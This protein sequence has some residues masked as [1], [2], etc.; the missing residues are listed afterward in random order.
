MSLLTKR[1][2]FVNSQP[3]YWGRSVWDG[4]K[5]VTSGAYNGPPTEW[6]E[7]R[8]FSSVNTPGFKRLKKRAL[9]NNPFHAFCVKMTDSF[10]SVKQVGP[11]GTIYMGTGRAEMSTSISALRQNLYGPSYPNILNET[12]TRALK[13][14][15]NMKFNAAQAFAERRQTANLL[16]STANRVVSLAVLLREGKFEAA[17]RMLRGRVKNFTPEYR[18]TRNTIRRPT[19]KD[20]ESSWLEYSYGWRPLLGD[21]YGSAELLAQTFTETRPSKATGRAQYSASWRNSHS[22]SGLTGVANMSHTVKAIT[23]IFYDVDDRAADV[24]R[25]TGISNP[26]LLAWELIPYSFVVDWFLPVGSYLTALAAPQGLKFV[27]GYECILASGRGA[28]SSTSN[29]SLYE[30]Q[31]NFIATAQWAEIT[32]HGLS[33]FPVV[34]FPSVSIGLNLSQFASGYALLKQVFRR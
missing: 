16:I 7:S 30:L 11:T 8:Q 34:D 5:Y 1:A 15:S 20:F 4:S 3:T 33:S 9:P 18:F 10:G 32:R 2:P 14:M 28:A 12:R 19:Q 24:L 31:G 23:E 22:D 25:S 26:A 17:N 21:I 13:N 27:G 29:N 6:I